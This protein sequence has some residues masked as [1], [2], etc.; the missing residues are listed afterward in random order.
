MSQTIDLLIKNGSCFVDGKLKKV[1]LV[2][3]NSKI[4]EIG[5]LKKL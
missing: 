4:Q 2:V 3:N 1:D 5:E